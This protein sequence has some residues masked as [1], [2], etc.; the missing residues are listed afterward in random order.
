MRAGT[1]CAARPS[2]SACRRSA[3]L[4]SCTA[5][6]SRLNAVGLFHANRKTV[7]LREE[8]AKPRIVALTVVVGVIEK[9]KHTVVVATLATDAPG[10]VG[11]IDGRDGAVVA[12]VSTTLF[13]AF[14]PIRVAALVRFLRFVAAHGAIGSRWAV[15]RPLLVFF[16]P[17]LTAQDHPE[18]E[19][20]VAVERPLD[21]RQLGVPPVTVADLDVARPQQCTPTKPRQSHQ[22]PRSDPDFGATTMV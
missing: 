10:V 18:V 8:A 7:E 16:L 3:S 1:P 11:S 13:A 19:L 12:L 6:P 5:T 20:D 22:K 2:T 17:R 15:G 14:A 9:L 4:Q 21:H